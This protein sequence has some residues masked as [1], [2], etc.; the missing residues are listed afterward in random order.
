LRDNFSSTS[1]DDWDA[2]T[3]RSQKREE[4][5]KKLRKVVEG[6][7]EPN[8]P[9]EPQPPKKRRERRRAPPYT[10]VW[11]PEV[12]AHPGI[13]TNDV[14]ELRK[15]AL[16]LIHLAE[17][18]LQSDPLVYKLNAT[19]QFG[20]VVWAKF[21]VGKNWFCLELR[22]KKI[23]EYVVNLASPP[24]PDD[25]PPPGWTLRN[26]EEKTSG[27]DE[28]RREAD[29]GDTASALAS[30]LPSDIGREVTVLWRFTRRKLRAGFERYKTTIR[31]ASERALR[32]ASGIYCNF[33]Y[34]LRVLGASLRRSLRR[35]ASTIATDSNSFTRMREL[36]AQQ[37]GFEAHLEARRVGQ[38]SGLHI[39]LYSWISDDPP[40]VDWSADLFGVLPIDWAANLFGVLPEEE[41][42]LL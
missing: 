19:A 35:F 33:A 39:L 22:H 40:P 24:S 34:S 26:G 8:E 12:Q 31:A 6:R 27:P 30:A 18:A 1:E 16:S 42:A 32:Q 3:L 20:D 4:A 13:T 25:L 17:A 2:V 41:R 15:T 9:T 11:S 29:G 14:I 28:M 36:S 38:H 10:L 5:L 37:I 21:Q 23:R 7:M